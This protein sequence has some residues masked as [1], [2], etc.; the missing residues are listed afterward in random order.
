MFYGIGHLT[1]FPRVGAISNRQPQQHC[2]CH[3]VKMQFTLL[4]TQST[5]YIYLL[6]FFK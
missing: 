3:N 1:N 5:N 4:S 6:S 2:S